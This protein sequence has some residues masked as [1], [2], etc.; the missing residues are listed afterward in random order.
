M[1]RT[2]RSDER[3]EPCFMPA[4]RV[5]RSDRAAPKAILVWDSEYVDTVPTNP[6]DNVEST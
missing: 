4:R 6:S 1:K 2:N 3:T 5:K